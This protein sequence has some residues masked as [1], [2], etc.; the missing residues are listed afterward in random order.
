MS[1][2][3]HH[4]LKVRNRPFRCIYVNFFNSFRFLADVIKILQK[5]HILDNFRTITQKWCMETGQRTRLF[6]PS[7][8]ALTV[9]KICFLI[10]KYSKFSFMW[11][12]L[13][14]ILVCRIP[15]FL[16]KSYQ[17]RLIII[18]FKKVDTLMSL[19][20]YFVFCPLARAK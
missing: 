20:I 10:W 13:W 7:F 3:Q 17:F 11:S 4:F 12:H 5:M 6:P 8:S 19:K 9:C 14:S 16:A 1:H 18:L 2:K 15:Q